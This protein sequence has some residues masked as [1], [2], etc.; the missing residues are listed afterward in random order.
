MNKTEFA[1]V[2]AERT[3]MTVTQA[4]HVTDEF[5]D[6]LKQGVSKG[7]RIAFLGFGTFSVTRRAARTGVN[8]R[9]PSQ[10]VKIPARNVVRFTP[11][12]SLKDA[13]N[14]KYKPVKKATA[15]VKKDVKKVAATAKKDVKKVAAT[16]KKVE[17]KA[18]GTVKKTVKKA[19]T[20][21]KRPAAKKP[22][23]KKPAAK[24][25]PRKRK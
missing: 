11:G 4:V 6:L 9:N 10:K 2:L 17:K 14:G 5:L 22:A 8:P 25:A 12:T 19:T 7:E 23:A 13:A 24:A 20:A 18:A 15:T 21:A 16:A 3:D 1:K